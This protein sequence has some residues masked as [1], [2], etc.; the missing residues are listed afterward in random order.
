MLV[1]IS[2]LIALIAAEVVYRLF[3]GNEHQYSVSPTSNQYN[4]YQFDPKLGWA[5]T[6]GASGTYRRS[7]F[8]YRISI[9][10]YGMRQSPVDKKK[11]TA[12][13]RIAVLGDSFVWG[14]GINDEHRLTEILERMLPYVEVLNFGTSGYSP[15]QYFLMLDDVIEFQPDLVVIVFCLGNDFIDNVLYQRY[16]YYK[17]Y[18][19][20]DKNGKLKIKGYPLPNIKKFGFKNTS[21]FLGSALL[22]QLRN[23]Y[24]LNN[25]IQK[26]LIGFT[27]NILHID[28]ANLSPLQRKLKSKA[29][30]INEALLRAIHNTLEE[31]NVPL[32]VASAPTKRE[33][34]K[35]RK[36]GHQGYYPSVELELQ[37]SANKLGIAFIPNVYKLNGKDF[38]V[39]DGHWNPLGHKKMAASIANFII[40]KRYLTANYTHLKTDRW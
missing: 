24:L 31:N 20:V 4:F 2:S 28:D 32:I 16:R 17:P 12:K 3:L 33:Y 36:Y 34:N 5:N 15:V 23:E 13:Y 29:I 26:G 27:N 40:D 14:I 9:N 11:A 39:K 21:Y 18:A 30:R 7:E 38:W 37:R 22:G 19:V 25:L 8:S 35:N 1:L 6:P 10:N